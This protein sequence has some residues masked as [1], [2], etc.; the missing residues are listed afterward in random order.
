MEPIVRSLISGQLFS[1]VKSVAVAVMI[2]GS[3]L[4]SVEPCQAQQTRNSTRKIRVKPSPIAAKIGKGVNWAENVETALERSR[5]TGK[6]VFWYVPTIGGSFMDRKPVIDR[7]MMAGPFSWESTR[8]A[9]NN[10]FIPVKAVPSRDEQE[11][12]GLKPYKFVEP[13]FLVLDSDQT[14]KLK[15]D[16]ITTLHPEWFQS[17]LGSAVD[18]GIASIEPDEP[19]K[20]IQN[21]MNAAL[22][23][24]RSGEHAQAAKAWQ[25]IAQEHPNHPLGWKA[26]AEA[27]GFGPIVRGFEVRAGVPNGALKAGI[28]SAGSAAPKNTYGE[29]E[30][31]QRGLKFLLGM[32]RKDGGFVDCDYDFGG[33]DSL[34][35]VHVAVTALAGMAMLANRDRFPDQ[36]ER[37]DV[38]IK[39]AAE[40]VVNDDNIAKSDRDEIL[41][42]YAYRVRFLS[43]LIKTHPELVAELQ[44]CVESLEGIKTRRGGWYHE[45]NNPFVTATALNA[46]SEARSA[47]ANVD[48]SKITEGVASLAGDRFNNG[49]YPY[50]SSR[51]PQGESKPGT[52]RQIAASAGRMPLCELGLWNWKEAT[53]D[54]LMSAITISFDMHHHLTSALKY[55]DHTSNMAYGGFFFWYDMRGRSEAISK[56]KDEQIRAGFESKQKEI[57]LSLPELDGCFVDSHELGRCYGTAMALLSLDLLD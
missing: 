56:I 41:W 46:L 18:G 53:D 28:E 1:S 19:T 31:I 47:G 32:Q 6:P 26:A 55:D 7:Y 11:K 33:T 8:Q 42:A 49:A 12:Y 43:R 14:L 27:E 15:V 30:L 10:H 22:E 24:F 5:E 48:S 37:I 25:A 2:F 17:L 38:A 16:R 44:R 50:G 20:V 45:Y 35:N 52:A 3:V 4:V 13:G 34:P 29:E 36:K 23:I 39:R 9:I 51:G 57:I 54:R 40:F 21:Q